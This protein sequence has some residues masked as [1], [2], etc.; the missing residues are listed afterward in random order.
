MNIDF[1]AVANHCLDVVQNQYFCFDGRVSVKSYWTYTI[2]MIIVSC[3]PGI[4]QLVFLI[5]LLPSLGM[6]ARRLHDT[7]KS[8]WLQVI[9]VIPVIG[10]IILLYLCSL[11]AVP[12]DNE[13]GSAAE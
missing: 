1:K 3:I 4:G 6:N 13:F 11:P 12:G 10:V 2:P 8:G 9:A 5:L 7:G